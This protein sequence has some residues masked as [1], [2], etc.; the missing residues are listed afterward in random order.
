MFHLFRHT[1]NLAIDLG[2]ANTLVY[3][4]DRG[5]VLN[6]PSMLAFDIRN[7]KILAIGQDAKTMEGKTPPHIVIMRPMKDGV[8]ADFKMT[9]AMLQHFIRKAAK[10]FRFLSPKVVIA[11]PFGITDVE[12]KAVRDSAC[13]AGASK[14]TII[15]EPMAAALGA[16]LPVEKP[17]GSMVV[18][19]GGGTTDV[20]VIVM[21]EII[22]GCCIRTAGDEMDGAII[23]H[24]RQKHNLLIGP[25]TAEHIKQTIGCAYSFNG[26]QHAK[27]RGRE[28]T[29][30]RFLTTEI[31]SEEIQEALT[32]TVETI[33]EAVMMTLENTP[34]DLADDI[35]ER[36][37]L[38]TGGG[39]LLK[40]LDYKIKEATGLPVA[41]SDDALTTVAEGAGKALT[42]PHLLR[43]IAID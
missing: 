42:T 8:I 22:S 27:I 16:G 36:G 18:D 19:I 37:I 9:R 24:V 43:K 33:V 6:E 2:T 39:A 25:R 10:R 38:L 11:V 21:T 13:H 15:L 7:D 3:V 34:P 31:S 30:R 40:N 1:C 17:I 14:V 26:E 35:I 4:P 20:A 5:I 41:L 28:L 29:G 23:Q 32:K 12:K